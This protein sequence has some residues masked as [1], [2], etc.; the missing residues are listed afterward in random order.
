MNRK[1]E[2]LRGR[3]GDEVMLKG[4]R[5][6]IGLTVEYLNSTAQECSLALSQIQKSF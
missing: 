4:L 1:R 5:A 2:R 3:E 6:K